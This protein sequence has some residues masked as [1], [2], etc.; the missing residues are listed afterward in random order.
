[1]SVYIT[2][3]THGCFSRLLESRMISSMQTDKEDYLIIA[4]DF[5]GLFYGT[6]EEENLLDLLEEVAPFKILF[7]DGN[8][9]N[10]EL[11]KRYPTENW[12]GGEV[13]FIRPHIIHL[14][15]GYCYTI[16]KR[17]FFAMG[18]AL[19]PDITDGILELDDPERENKIRKLEAEGKIF[20]RTRGLD[21]F[22]EEMPSDEELQ[23]GLDTLK[24]CGNRVDYILTHAAPSTLVNYFSAGRFAPNKL[25][26][27]FEKLRKQ[28]EF[29][30]WY[31]GH[32][33]AD[34][35]FLLEG[36]NYQIL[37]C[38]IVRIC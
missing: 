29:R 8:H 24:A 28:V 1:M 11:L 20:Y 10:F 38:H 35:K 36:K 22:P 2:G 4:G 33:H 27:Y 37:Y 7:V 14:M 23:R 30:T 18:G 32:Y 12:H 25:T 6:K 26:E 16:E 9:E 19:S 17:T 13:Q 3:D 34:E 5:G 31:C 21:W 15:R